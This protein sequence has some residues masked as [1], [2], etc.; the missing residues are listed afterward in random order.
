MYLSVC[1]YLSYM[2]CDDVCVDIANKFILNDAG[3][4]RFFYDLTMN[5]HLNVT[6]HKL[7]HMYIERERVVGSVDR[8]IFVHRSNLTWRV[9]G[10]NRFVPWN[11][12]VFYNRG[13]NDSRTH[14]YHS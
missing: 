9:G 14:I 4:N 3:R 2:V 12:I 1:V 7:S 6:R 13:S 8:S 10:W 5:L 11:T